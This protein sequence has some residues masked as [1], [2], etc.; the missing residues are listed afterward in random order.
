MRPFLLL[1]LA[2]LCSSLCAADDLKVTALTAV[3]DARVSAMLK[4]S[5]AALDTVLSDD[6]RYAHSN[7]KVDT[8]ASLTA[9]LLGGAA[10]YVSYKYSERTFK[11]PAPDV[12][13]MAG[14]L[15][16]QAFVDGVS[17]TTGISYL[18]VWRLEQG[19]WKFLAWQSCK[20][21]PATPAK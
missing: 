11:F 19:Q 16:V 4:P 21:P 9:S 20:I 14:R 12:A 18:A 5:K 8:K 13:L 17:M 15:E 10:K 1:T 6:L 7:G 2:F 3:D